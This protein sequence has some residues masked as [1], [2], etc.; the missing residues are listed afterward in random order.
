MD[1]RLRG[2]DETKGRRSKGLAI[3]W[4]AWRLGGFSQANA[5]S[6]H[7]D[8]TDGRGDGYR[9]RGHFRPGTAIE[10]DGVVVRIRGL[11]RAAMREARDLL[12]LP[13]SVEWFCDELSR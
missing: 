1:P 10:R 12:T 5:R 2:G 13:L 3:P 6:I 11:R 4:R 7:H 8:A 9:L